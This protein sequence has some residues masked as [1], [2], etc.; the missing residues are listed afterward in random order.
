MAGRHA[1]RLVDTFGQVTIVERDPWRGPTAR[2]GTPQAAYV[3]VLL[4]AGRIALEELFPGFEDAV[5]GM[6]G[7]TIDAGSDLRYFQDGTFLD[8]A[9]DACRC[10]VPAARRANTSW[11]PRFNDALA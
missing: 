9:T 6:A 5:H 1:A 4:E 3:H 8:E 2:D 7:V 11:G 10:S